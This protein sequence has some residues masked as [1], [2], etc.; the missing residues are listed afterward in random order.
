MRWAAVLALLALAAC[1]TPRA[2]VVIDA[3]PGG[4]SV[5]PRVSGNLGG[6]AVT[7]QG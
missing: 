2:G 4:V 7:V 3:G 6:L 5:S 1:S